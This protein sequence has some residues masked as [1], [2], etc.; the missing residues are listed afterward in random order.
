M[1]MLTLTA[2]GPASVMV[3]V[4]TDPDIPR[5]FELRL[6]VIEFADAIGVM[7]RAAAKQRTGTTIFKAVI[8]TVR[9][10]DMTKF[11]PHLVLHGRGHTAGWL[12][13]LT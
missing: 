8:L 9:I 7:A 1:L 3:T 12:R 5:L 10:P 13:N 2:L 11:I 6:K 4:P